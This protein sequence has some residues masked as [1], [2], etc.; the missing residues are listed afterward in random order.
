MW[1]APPVRG[2]GE[3]AP[4]SALWGLPGGQ[5]GGSLQA[6]PSTAPRHSP[7]HPSRCRE[8]RPPPPSA[9]VLGPP[10]RRSSHHRVAWEASVGWHCGLCQPL[11][12]AQVA[13]A[14]TLMGE[15]AVSGGRDGARGAGQASDL[16]PA[17]APEHME[18]GEQWLRR[19]GE[20]SSLP[21]P[22]CGHLVCLSWEPQHLPAR[23]WPPRP[24]SLSL[25]WV[26]L[27]CPG[28]PFPR[29]SPA[30]RPLQ[31]RSLTG[32]V[33]RL[34][35]CELHGKAS[36]GRGWGEWQRLLAGCPGSVPGC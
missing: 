18:G 5:G 16:P 1:A 24:A 11:A 14:H 23:A 17:P 34:P 27:P 31:P 25:L 13:C 10:G 21:G 4:R 19:G 2:P 22:T 8:S 33:V 6:A 9:T 28:N 36:G 3:G 29:G 32:H 15:G 30:L 26:K 12:P 7:P 35:R 20:S